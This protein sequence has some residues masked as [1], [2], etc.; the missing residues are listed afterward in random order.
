MDVSKGDKVPLL[1]VRGSP[2]RLNPEGT[3]TK[4]YPEIMYRDVCYVTYYGTSAL[5]KISDVFLARSGGNALAWPHHVPM[6]DKN[7]RMKRRERDRKRYHRDPI[8]VRRL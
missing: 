7:R 2:D 8:G 3:V 6:D 4:I 5:F 1:I